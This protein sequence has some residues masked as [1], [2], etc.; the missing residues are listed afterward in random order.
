MYSRAL[1]FQ[2]KFWSSSYSSFSHRLSEKLKF[3]DCELFFEPPKITYTQLQALA[4]KF[5]EVTRPCYRYEKVS[6]GCKLSNAPTFMIMRQT[7]TDSTTL[8]Q[9]DIFTSKKNTSF[10]AT[11]KMCLKIGKEAYYAL[12]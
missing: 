4:E 6:L 5:L 7:Q 8:V 1:S 12:Q 9:N 10:K 2:L 11:L 3:H